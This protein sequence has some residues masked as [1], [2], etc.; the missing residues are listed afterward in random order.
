M[1][2]FI[3]AA[4]LNVDAYKTSL[5]N[6][7]KSQN[8]FADYDFEGSNLAT[9]LALLSYNTFN[10][11][12]YLNMVGSEMFIDSAQ[13]RESI[14]SHAKELNYTPRSRVSAR[15][16]VVVQV[17][18]NDNPASITIPPYYALRTTSQQSNTIRFITDQPIVINRDANNQYI[19]D[20]FT[21]YEGYL[22]TEVFEVDNAT[23]DGGF[24]TYGQRFNLQ[25][26][27]ID[28]SS[29]VVSVAA[30]IADPNPVVYTRAHDLYGLD[31]DSAV[32]FVRGYK[33][34]YYEL[35]F[36]DGVLGKALQNGNIV[37][38]KYRDTVGSEGNGSYT[39]TKTSSIDGYSSIAVSTVS[40][41]T[42]GAERESNE[43]IKYNA[44]RHFQTQNRAIVE[45]D[46]QVLIR[47]NFPEIEQVYVFGGEQ[48]YQ[49][50]KV[51]IVL[52]PDNN[53]G[54][55]TDATKT[56]IV[57]F[58][59][60]KNIVPEPVIL[61]PEYYYLNINSTVYYSL[62]STSDRQAEIKSDIINAIDRLT[63]TYF[64][65]FNV[66]VYQSKITSTITNAHQAVVGAD[67]DLSMIKRWSPQVGLL[68]NYTFTT[69]NPIISSSSGA[70]TTSTTYGITT[71]QF[72]MIID[73]QIETVVLRDNGV[74]EIFIYIV[75]SDATL[76]KYTPSIGTVD[77]AT[78]KI[79]IQIDPYQYTNYIAF[80][81]KLVNKSI[82][83]A[84][85]KFILIDPADITLTMV[86]Q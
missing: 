73:D 69:D 63:D 30:S 14:V 4:Q 46:Y 19:S 51:M 68:Q 21:V 36:G 75:Q 42:G 5:K 80:Q 23:I 62:L 82:D 66:D 32:Y 12:F 38:V 70:Y 77:Y 74:G 48:I 24:T 31:G 15:T 56:R 43:S 67:V 35:E 81:C 65:D 59:K 2:D 7:L 22:V 9:L 72:Q 83:I 64:A 27:N 86:K 49:Y 55:V 37:T 79:S 40:R 33:D 25:S 50:G 1:A 17:T 58:L 53:L 10:D 34:N 60:T 44:V 16:Q 41:A 85:N 84:R 76:D 52:K 54:S 28:A 78:G 39:L 8:Q 13:L 45:S 61:D 26:A 6:F 18:P 3:P 47:N 20:Q 57:E 29:I 71:N 11:G